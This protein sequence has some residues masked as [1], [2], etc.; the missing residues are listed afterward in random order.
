MDNCPISVQ[1]PVTPDDTPMM[2]IA[3]VDHHLDGA[4][5]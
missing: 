2:R 4:R 1:P 5:A 3:M